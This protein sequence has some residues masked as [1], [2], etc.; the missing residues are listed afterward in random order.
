MTR[1]TIQN[2]ISHQLANPKGIGG[3]LVARLMAAANKEMYD[4]MLSRS[5]LLGESVLEIGFGGGKHLEKVYGQTMGG[6]L[7]GLDISES[8]VKYASR[9]NR[10][11][12]N[13][14]KLFLYKGDSSDLPFKQSEFDAVISLNTMY[15]WKEP[16]EDMN[17]IYTVLKPGGRVI[18]GINSKEE[19]QKNAYREKY[20][21]FFDKTEVEDLL[22]SAGYINI[23]HSYKRLRIEDCHLFVAEKPYKL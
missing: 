23:N 18:I 1:L 10:S 12:I 17:N 8:M 7:Y 5:G 14:E 2:I 21:K 15:F 9:I 3:I 13:E 4:Y 20:L 11:L 6:K 19:L 16:S 22:H